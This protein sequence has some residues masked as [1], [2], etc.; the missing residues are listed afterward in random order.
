MKHLVL[1]IL[2]T[3]IACSNSEPMKRDAYNTRICKAVDFYTKF[4]R[5]EISND[6]IVEC[7]VR[8]SSFGSNMVC[9]WI[10]GEDK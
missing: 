7:V 4:C 1:I 3:S 6:R 9:E 5:I 8:R 10:K 2:I